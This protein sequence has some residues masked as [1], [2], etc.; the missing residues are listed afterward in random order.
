MVLVQC[1]VILFSAPMFALLRDVSTDGR[2]V[3]F[4]ILIWTF[5]IST[6]GLLI[7]PKVGAFRRARRDV[8]PRPGRASGGVRVSGVEIPEALSASLAARR[9]SSVGPRADPEEE[10]HQISLGYQV[11]LAERGA[12]SKQSGITPIEE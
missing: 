5:P 10:Q 3:G 4:V 11:D 7:G 6:L 9:E 1:E 12:I 8:N 2:Y